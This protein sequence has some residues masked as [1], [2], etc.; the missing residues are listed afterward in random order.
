MTAVVQPNN[1]MHSGNANENGNGNGRFR[2][3]FWKTELCRFWRS[4]CRNGKLCP[5]A[6]GDEELTARPDLAK[7]SLCQRWAK[8]SCP[9]EATECRFAHGHL[10][11]RATINFSQSPQDLDLNG[12]MND[13]GV[14]QT[15]APILSTGSPPPLGNPR[16]GQTIQSLPPRMWEEDNYSNMHAYAGGGSSANMSWASRNQS[17]HWNEAVLGQRGD[18]QWSADYTDSAALGLAAGEDVRN[19]NG[20]RRRPKPTGAEL[21]LTPTSGS[22][23]GVDPAVPSNGRPPPP[24]SS[25]PQQHV[26][27]LGGV[28]GVPGQLPVN[29]RRPHEGLPGL[30]LTESPWARGGS[31]LSNGGWVEPCQ[32]FDQFDAFAPPASRQ[33]YNAI[34]VPDL[35]QAFEFPH[36]ITTPDTNTTSSSVPEELR[37]IWG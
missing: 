34:S 11:L 1:R 22:N 26:V 5:F 19:R 20:R 37:A 9:L 32:A 36:A 16:N 4:G 2:A 6:H 12:Q 29:G 3:Q 8:G 24:A 31:G 35:P 25:P 10:D 7:T 28:P 30:T 23:L 21:G 18:W 14:L 13:P 27:Q 17:S 33:P 15:E